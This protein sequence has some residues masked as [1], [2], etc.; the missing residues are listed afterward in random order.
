MT[1][2]KPTVSE[3]IDLAMDG[4]VPR[5]MLSYM[6][7]L[8][9]LKAIA[10]QKDATA[11][12]FWR[13]GDQW[14]VRSA[15]DKD[16]ALAFF[17]NEW[18]PT[19]IMSPW[20]KDSGFQ[21]GKAAKAM[22]ALNRVI[23]EE[24]PRFDVWRTVCHESRMAA[25]DAESR[26]DKDK[27]KKSWILRKCRNGFPDSAL[28]WFDAVFV[29]T[30]ESSGASFPPLFGSGGN[31]GRFEIGAKF[32]DCVEQCLLNRNPAESE[33]R[34]ESALF[35]SK[36][37]SIKNKR[38][39]TLGFFD[40]EASSQELI[41]PWDFVLAMEGVL[42][43]AGSA[44]R[45]LGA[46]ARSYAAFPFMASSSS[47]AG[48]QTVSGDE[49]A[50][51]SKGE[52]WT[53]VWEDPASFRDVKLLMSEGR[54]EIGGRQ[55]GNSVDFVRAISGLGVR[56]GISAFD[57]YGFLERNGQS[58]IATWLDRVPVPAEPPGASNALFDLDRPRRNAGSA[59]ASA[60][61]KS[62]GNR[63]EDAVYRFAKNGGGAL[64]LQEVLLRVAEVER[65]A[66]KLRD[67][68]NMPP[69]YGLQRVWER[70][71]NDGS[72][73]F[74]LALSL[75]SII[76]KKGWYSIRENLEPVEVDKRGNPQWTADPKGAFVWNALKDPLLNMAAVLERRCMDSRRQEGVVHPALDGKRRLASLEDV[77]EFLHGR[78][79]ARR[80]GDLALA[81]SMT[82][83]GGEPFVLRPQ[84]EEGRRRSPLIPP[85]YAAMKLTLL[86][87][88][89]QVGGRRGSLV[90]I[91][92]PARIASEAALI[93]LLRAGR[94]EEAYALASRRLNASTGLGV[95]TENPQIADGRGN[96]LRLAAA[97]LFPIS[98]K[99]DSILANA[100]LRPNKET[101]GEEDEE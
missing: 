18:Q 86:P 89:I 2:V 99:A 43:F 77:V 19:P 37:P 13:N 64:A 15:L 52:L 84:R 70:E 83:M 88:D 51:K 47:S 79:D 25:E 73:E 71:A 38:V 7:A 100:A 5:D 91:E 36:S 56:R 42:L 81:L 62:L 49:S 1:A 23:A 85:A 44:S 24:T 40:A 31:D 30:D 33:E 16:A 48:S 90:S 50:S 26:F 10:E 76:G 58:R 93:P 21:P 57:R 12:G 65:Y 68:D 41:N 34:L 92:E 17:M 55:A 60:A 20:N 96:G 39:G 4:C 9:I 45:R 22:D 61:M 46:G 28:E 59:K 53:P 8:G 11:Q 6:K 78:V 27:D 82:A 74:R 14:V 32:V 94:V 67:G 98:E 97:L 95:K 69:I 75:A 3:R 87:R 54:A 35:A 80:V 101:D 66:G 29:L 63:L 72:A